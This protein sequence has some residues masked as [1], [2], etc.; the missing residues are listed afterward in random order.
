MASIPI[1]AVTPSFKSEGSRSEPPT[2]LTISTS[3]SAWQRV[4]DGPLHALVIKDIDIVVHYDRRASYRDQQPSTAR[5]AFFPCPS[6]F[7]SMDT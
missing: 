7:F 1:L 5:M 6:V 4:P 3:R 2:L